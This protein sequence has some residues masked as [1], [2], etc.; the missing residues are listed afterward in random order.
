TPYGL[1]YADTEEEAGRAAGALGDAA[2]RYALHFGH[3]PSGAL[4]LSTDLDPLGAR[5][6]ARTLGPD[7]APVSLPA[8]APQASTEPAARPPPGW[9]TPRSGCPPVRRR[10]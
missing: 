6:H 2:R 1:A 4:I 9:P 7:S 5:H 8:R 3:A 10:P